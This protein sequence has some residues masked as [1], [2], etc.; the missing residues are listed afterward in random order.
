[1]A[2]EQAWRVVRLEVNP[3]WHRLYNAPLIKGPASR[4]NRP[5]RAF[6]A[7]LGDTRSKERLQARGNEDAEL[8]RLLA[9]A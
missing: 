8:A 9:G 4:P 2:A 6:M 1:M 3:S 7:I 5:F